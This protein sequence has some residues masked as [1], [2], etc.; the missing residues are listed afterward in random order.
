MLSKMWIGQLL[1]LESP[2]WN[3]LFVLRIILAPGVFESISMEVLVSIE[4][5]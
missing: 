5:Q 1:R 2:E 4:D 3:E